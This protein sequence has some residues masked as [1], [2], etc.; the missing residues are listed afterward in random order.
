VSNYLSRDAGR[1]L[2]PGRLLA[3]NQATPITFRA[4]RSGRQMVAKV[5]R[6]WVGLSD[7][8]VSP[9]HVV[10]YALANPLET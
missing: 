7:G 1:E 3:G 5:S 10:A 6:G 9:D 2:W 8:Q 4:P